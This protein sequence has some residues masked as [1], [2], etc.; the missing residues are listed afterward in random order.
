MN[1]LTDTQDTALQHHFTEYTE[2]TWDN[3][4]NLLEP[5]QDEIVC[6]WFRH[7]NTSEL[8]DM[9]ICLEQ[10]LKDF[11]DEGY[12]KGMDAMHLQHQGF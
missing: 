2:D 9:L 6:D 12:V 5:N 7:N 4:M 1:K 11:Y 3:M 10:R 8:R